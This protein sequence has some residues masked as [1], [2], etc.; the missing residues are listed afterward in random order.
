MM[1]LA[2]EEIDHVRY[3]N[4]RHKSQKRILLNISSGDYNLALRECETLLA[5]DPEN[6]EIRTLYDETSKANSIERLLR[7]M[8]SS[9]EYTLLERN[10]KIIRDNFEISKVVS[11]DHARRYFFC[12]KRLE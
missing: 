11:M 3:Y 2:R 6:E 4:N 5:E 12:K 9:P 8:E 10:L 1:N 7:Q